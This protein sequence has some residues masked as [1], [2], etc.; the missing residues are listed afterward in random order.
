MC[1]K[2]QKSVW[3]TWTKLKNFMKI[4]MSIS[5]SNFLLLIRERSKRILLLWSQSLNSICVDDVVIKWQS[6]GARY[7]ITINLFDQQVVRTFFFNLIFFLHLYMCNAHCAMNIFN[8]EDAIYIASHFCLP[9]YC[10]Y[11]TQSIGELYQSF[12]TNSWASFLM[13]Y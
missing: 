12:V 2:V 3:I 7:T 13:Y 4:F 1:T 10:P 8:I 11:N 9:S 6:K 5:L